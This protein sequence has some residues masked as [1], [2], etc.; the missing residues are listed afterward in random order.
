MD[1]SGG[2]KEGL[3]VTFSLQRGNRRGQLGLSQL[4]YHS[5][6]IMEGLEV[7]PCLVRGPAGLGIFC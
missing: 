2:H 4:D 1:S 6:G 7:L 3:G 5:L